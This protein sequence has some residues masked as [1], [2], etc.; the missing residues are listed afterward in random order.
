MMQEE[1]IEVVAAESLNLGATK[2]AA[3]AATPI[4]TTTVYFTDG[5]L[6]PWKGR[7]FRVHLN[8]QT[9]KIELEMLKS[10]AASVKRAER[11]QRW[12]QQHPHSMRAVAKRA[13]NVIK[14]SV[15]SSELSSAAR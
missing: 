10:T 8:Q 13:A 9:K 3:A 4:P 5:E 1:N 15:V 14:Q 7:W 12:L 6:L 2:D 11:E